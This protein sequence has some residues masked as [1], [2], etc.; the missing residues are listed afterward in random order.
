MSQGRGRH[1]RRIPLDYELIFVTKGTLEMQAGD[2]DYAVRAGE[3]LLLTPQVEHRGTADYEPNLTYFFVHFLP[4]PVP[5]EN[6]LNQ[7]SMQTSVPRHCKVERPDYL[8]EL[9]RR[10]LDDQTGSHS[11]PLSRSLL[12]WLILSESH[13][14]STAQH[15]PGSLVL[16]SL[17]DSHI[18]LNF[19]QRLTTA[20]IA[21]HLG[22]NPQ[23]LSRVYH[24]AFGQTLTTTIHRKRVTQACHLL[25]N[26]EMRVGEI[27]RSCGMEDVSYFLQLFKRHKGMTATAFRRLHARNFI[28]T[29]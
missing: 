29:E 11:D 4:H 23:Y 14:A 19:Q 5:Q 17:A 27:A 28:G 18:Q 8:A 1:V 9:F 13:P 25:L 22:C 10:Y 15:D 26:S 12:L 7:S 6:S 3:T 16:A 2:K 20:V 24:Q 21:E